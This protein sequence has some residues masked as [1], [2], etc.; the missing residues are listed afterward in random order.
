MSAEERRVARTV[1]DRRRYLAK[2]D[3]HQEQGRARNQKRRTLIREVIDAYLA[4]HPCV[5]C[6]ESDPVVLDFDHLG[7]KSFNIAR[8]ATYLV[9]I[10]KLKAEIAK[11]AIRCANCHRRKTHVTH[12]HRDKAL[13]SRSGIADAK[14]ARE[15]LAGGRDQVG[16]AGLDTHVHSGTPNDLRWTP[17]K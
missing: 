16:L 12:G 14:K 2:Q 10:E 15:G 4:A 17:P 1:A 7:D 6:G 8:A 9:P 3:W 13:F 11:C 5:D